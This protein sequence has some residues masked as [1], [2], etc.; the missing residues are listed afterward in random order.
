MLSGLSA[1][2]RLARRVSGVS[3]SK[4]AV[5]LHNARLELCSH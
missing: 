2:S 4:S 1:E 3:Q 5:M